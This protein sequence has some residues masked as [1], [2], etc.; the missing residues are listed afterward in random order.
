ML[1]E[2]RIWIERDDGKIM[3]GRT[4]ELTCENRYAYKR[5]SIIYFTPRFITWHSVPHLTLPGTRQVAL[6]FCLFVL[7]FVFLVFYFI[8][9]YFIF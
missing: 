6:F 5:T 4:E 9:F 7:F 3:S 8:L 2:A 1:K